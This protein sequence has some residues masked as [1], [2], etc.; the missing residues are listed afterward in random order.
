VKPDAQAQAAKQAA[1]IEALR[2]PLPR[3]LSWVIA[4]LWVVRRILGGPPNP[5]EQGPVLSHAAAAGIHR[6]ESVIHPTQKEI[7]EI[8][9]TGL[10]IVL[11]IVG[12][13]KHVLA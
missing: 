7:I 6:G 5:A 4:D 10:A 13:V 3:S 8:V 12:K 1:A 11:A 9:S 2:R